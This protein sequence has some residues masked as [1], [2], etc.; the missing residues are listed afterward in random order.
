MFRL[1]LRC[2][3]AIRRGVWLSIRL[4]LQI[5]VTCFPHQV[6]TL[7]PALAIALTIALT[8]TLSVT[9]GRQQAGL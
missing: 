6:L 9:Y 8:L 7:T 2:S 3:L 5:S 4:Q 1:R